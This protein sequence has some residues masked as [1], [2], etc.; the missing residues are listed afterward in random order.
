MSTVHQ[1]D[2][3]ILLESYPWIQ[4]LRPMLSYFPIAE[5]GRWRYFTSQ[6]GISLGFYT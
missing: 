1:E 2:T 3:R 5:L 6:I 4:E